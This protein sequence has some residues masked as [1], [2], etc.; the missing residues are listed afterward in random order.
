MVAGMPGVTVCHRTDRQAQE[1]LLKAVWLRAEP[2]AAFLLIYFQCSLLLRSV[3][4][5]GWMLWMGGGEGKKK[6]SQIAGD[7]RVNT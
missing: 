7:G 1:P 4:T 5:M 2:S 3:S 6:T